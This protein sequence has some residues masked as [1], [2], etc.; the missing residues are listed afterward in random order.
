[1]SKLKDPQYLLNEQYQDA[2]NLNARIRLHI[3][4]SSNQYGWFPWVF[5]QYDLPKACRILELG[6]GSA[7]L[8]RDNM[9]RI[10]P[11]WQITLSDFSPGMVAQARQNLNSLPHPFNFK[12]IDAQAIPNPSA[13]FDAVIANHCLFHVPDRVKTLAE[14]HRILVPDG[15]FYATTIGETHMQELTNLV[16]AFDPEIGQVF[17]SEK[18]EFT[19]QNGEREILSWFP[20]VE[21]RRYLD[22][23]HVTDV[24]ALT[25]YILSMARLRLNENRHE[26]LARFVEVQM[27]ANNGMIRIHK[28][29]G[30]F[31][32]LNSNIK[33][34][35]P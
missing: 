33:S 21:T 10:P 27:N 34:L 3:E 18:F 12:I 2:K 32:A 28:D 9:A 20:Q 25:D 14:I 24:G 17:S 22:E 29:S 19:L 16:A 5:D 15:H 7:D 1:M 31:V 11:G 13:H 6:C 4:F 26:E 35:N 8:W 23:L 30:I